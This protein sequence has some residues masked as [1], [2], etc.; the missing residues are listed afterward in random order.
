MR[1]N[2]VTNKTQGGGVCFYINQG[3]CTSVT[4]RERICTPDVELLSVSLRPF[5]LPSE[6]PQLFITVVY[7]HP[8]AHAPSACKT[9]YEV[10]QKLQSISPE[11][12]AFILGD[13]NDV[14]LKKLVPNFHQYV[15]CP[16]RRDKTLDLWVSKGGI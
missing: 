13:F 3:Y 4:V 9:V 15:T 10:V 12:P 14:S 6:F 5:Y 1:I 7:I 8:R 2:V 11:S 16:T